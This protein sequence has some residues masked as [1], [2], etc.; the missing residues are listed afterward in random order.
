MHPIVLLIAIFSLAVGSVSYRMGW[1][2]GYSV[3][4]EILEEV[5]ELPGT[6][7]YDLKC[8]QITCN[9]SNTRESFLERVDGRTYFYDCDW[10]AVEVDD[11]VYRY[12]SVDFRRESDTCWQVTSIHGTKK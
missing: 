8:D 11:E 10:G 2:E 6:V 4:T 9:T 5:E 3:A 7:E 12:F 1:S